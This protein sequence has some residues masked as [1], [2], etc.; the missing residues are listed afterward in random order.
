MGKVGPY[1]SIADLCARWG[2]SPRTLRRWR[3]DVNGPPFYT[4]PI[5]EQPRGIG[6][7]Q[8]V[9]RYDL[10]ELL[11]YEETHGITPLN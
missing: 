8:P 4:V 10:A 5:W 2:K 3:E 1:L 9:V 6:S 7:H 11:A